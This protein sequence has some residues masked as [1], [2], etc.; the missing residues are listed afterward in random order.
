MVLTLSNQFLAKIPATPKTLTLPKTSSSTLRPQWSCRKSDIHPE[1]REDAKVY[2]NGELVMTTGG[3]QKDYT[4][5]VWSGNHPFYL[6][7]RSALLLD[8]DQVEKFRKK[9]GELTQIMEIPVLKGEIILPPKKK[10]KA[11]KK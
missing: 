8:A 7:N 4:V 3:T 2:C 9:Y 6:G 1:F 10:S 11:K 5:E